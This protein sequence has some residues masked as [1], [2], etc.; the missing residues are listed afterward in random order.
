MFVLVIIGVSGILHA[1]TSIATVPGFTSQD[2][3]MKAGYNNFNSV[4]G[5]TYKCVEVK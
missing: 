4:T 1:P 5:I 3:C 2:T